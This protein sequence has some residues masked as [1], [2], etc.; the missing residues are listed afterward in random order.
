MGADKPGDTLREILAQRDREEELREIMKGDPEDALREIMKR[1][2][3]HIDQSARCQQVGGYDFD[4]K[5]PQEKEEG[6]AV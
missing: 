1:D 2:R 3:P 4:G 5:H 6:D